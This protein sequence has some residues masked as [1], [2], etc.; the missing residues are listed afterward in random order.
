LGSLEPRGPYFFHLR[1]MVV[2]SLTLSMLYIQG[3][4]CRFIGIATVDMS[5]EACW[6]ISR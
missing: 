2:T 6:P 3:C 5:S 4:S 1:Q